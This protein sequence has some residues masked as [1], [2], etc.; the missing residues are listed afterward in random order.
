MTSFTDDN[1]R[2][3]L[4]SN[5]DGKGGYLVGYKRNDVYDGTVSG[6]LNAADKH[7]TPEMFGAAGDGV[8]DDIL[9]VQAAINYCLNNPRISGVQGFGCYAVSG[10]LFLRA[11]GYGFRF[12]LRSLVTH[13]NFPT[14]SSWK[15]ATPMIDIGTGAS[16]S[17]VGLNI[18]CDYVNGGGKANWI[19]INSYGCGGSHFHAGRLTNVVIGVHYNKFN[20]VSS[21][22]LISGDYWYNGWQAVRAGK[23]D[24]ATS[25][26]EGTRVNINF[27]TGFKYGAHHLS[28]GSQF[29]ELLGQC[30][31]NGRY[32]LEI[33]LKDPWVSSPVRGD[34]IT[35]GTNNGEILSIYQHP[36][37]TYKV[38]IGF[39]SNQSENASFSVGDSLT[40]T[41]GFS[42]EIQEINQP[43]LNNWYPD[44]IHDFYGYTFGKCEIRLPYCG[45]VVGG[46]IHSSRIN[47]YN[48]TNG[49]TNYN[50]GAMTTHSGTILSEYDAYYNSQIWAH[51]QSTYSRLYN[52]LYMGGKRIYGTE[53][54]VTLKQ[55]TTANIMTFTKVGDG[56]MSDLKEVWRATLTAQLT[57]VSGEVLIYVSSSALTLVN[58]SISGLNLSVDGLTIKAVQGSQ[59]TMRVLFNFQRIL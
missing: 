23:L 3:D 37:E 11:P 19:A 35:N 4:A 56:T 33:V 13:S 16:G 54:G 10:T 25:T 28:N 21:S 50:D 44:V 49:R 47:W 55:A 27:V 39:E 8:N 5:E 6:Y 29:S 31:F 36:V 22:N 2:E 43:S 30:D 51:V 9:A 48:S 12:Y 24:G 59:S 17:P 53:V 18:T 46:Y 20:Y 26:C 41:S 32:V 1:L 40:S 38:L 34:T 14:F 15:N 42:G 7:V 58:N 52:H 45:G 57:G